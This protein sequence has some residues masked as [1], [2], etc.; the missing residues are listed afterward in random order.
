M[1]KQKGR[2]KFF[3]EQKGYGFIVPKSDSAQSVFFHVSG[4]VGEFEPVTDDV[5][6]FSTGTDCDGRPKAIDVT[7]VDE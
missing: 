7:I 3:N 4:L 2:V 6:T 1:A 5:V